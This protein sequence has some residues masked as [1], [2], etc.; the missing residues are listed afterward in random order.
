MGDGVDSFAPHFKP[1]PIFLESSLKKHKNVYLENCFQD[2]ILCITDYILYIDKEA[3]WSI[4]SSRKR[5]VW[6][7]I[8]QKPDKGHKGRTDQ[9]KSFERLSTI[10]HR[11]EE[12]A[13]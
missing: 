6:K 4:E 10:S 7:Q 9:V 5:A 12:K 1:S 13:K 3:N 2:C 11:Y 8:Y